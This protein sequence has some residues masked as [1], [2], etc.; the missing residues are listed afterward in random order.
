MNALCDEFED[1]LRDGMQPA[2]ESFLDRIDSHHRELLL[3]ELLP[4]ELDAQAA[5]RASPSL[6]DSLKRFPN[7][8]DAVRQVFA[9]RY[10]PIGIDGLLNSIARAGLIESQLVQRLLNEVDPETAGNAA[11]RPVAR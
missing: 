5:S 8:T 6:E 4:I 1:A 7:H 11:L 10:P 3:R 9:E 2:I